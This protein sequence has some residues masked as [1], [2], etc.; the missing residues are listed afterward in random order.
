MT[1]TVPDIL[2]QTLAT[3]ISPI[4][5]QTPPSVPSLPGETVHLWR[6]LLSTD[7]AWLEQH[8]ALLSADEQARVHRFKF[9]LHRQRFTAAR[10]CLRLLLGAY[11][12]VE[13]QQIQFTYGPY[14]KPTL[15]A[16][17]AVLC[18]SLRFNLAHTDERA[19]YA[20]THNRAIGIDLEHIRPMPDALR[21]AQRFFTV[22]EANAIAQQPS[23]QQANAF[24]TLWTLKEAYLKATGEGLAGLQRARL[25]SQDTDSKL[26]HQWSL[27]SFTP[28]PGDRGAIAY[29]GTRIT[30]EFYDFSAVQH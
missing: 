21:I 12:N 2:D 19:L 6:S 28:F 26:L 10:C 11:L 8:R 27:Q 22:A 29:E 3:R 4:D 30:M 25:L 1:E 7:A 9:D 23:Q 18:P 5:W 20:F 14:G 24:F 17:T 13:P 16:N 15:A